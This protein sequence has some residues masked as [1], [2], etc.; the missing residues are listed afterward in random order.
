MQ[1]SDDF[2]ERAGYK[3]SPNSK[4]HECCRGAKIAKT[5]VLA[6]FVAK[7]NNCDASSRVG[8]ASWS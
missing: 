4:A 3:R 2:E 8:K 1:N 5:I 7:P 6:Q